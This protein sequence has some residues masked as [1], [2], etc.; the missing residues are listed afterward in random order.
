M[1]YVN[2]EYGIVSEVQEIDD[3][4][5]FLKICKTAPRQ[6]NLVREKYERE[7]GKAIQDILETYYGTNKFHPIKFRK[8]FTQKY[9]HNKDELYD[10][11]IE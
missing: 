7:A 6:N 11:I 9:L 10:L 5:D 3:L 1:T 4:D 8:L 2:R